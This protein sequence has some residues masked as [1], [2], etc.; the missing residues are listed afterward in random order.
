MKNQNY[1]KTTVALKPEIIN[2][3]DTLRHQYKMDLNLTIHR[4]QLVEL[5]INEAYARLVAEK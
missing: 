1:K 4:S 3:A 5:L 2:K